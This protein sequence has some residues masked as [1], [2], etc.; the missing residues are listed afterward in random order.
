MKG[1]KIRL[2]FEPT[3]GNGIRRM[4][5]GKIQLHFGT[6]MEYELFGG[7]IGKKI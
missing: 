4:Q 2:D 7:M 6:A 5:G 3:V 1:E